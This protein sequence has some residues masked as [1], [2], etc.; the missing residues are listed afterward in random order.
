MEEYCYVMRTKRLSGV[1]LVLIA[2]V[3]VGKWTRIYPK[4]EKYSIPTLFS[5]LREL[6]GRAYFLADPFIA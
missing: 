1:V 4:S 3:S 5:L 2:S 6:E